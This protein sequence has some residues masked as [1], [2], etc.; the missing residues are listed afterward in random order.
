M[1]YMKYNRKGCCHPVTSSHNELLVSSSSLWLTI[2]SILQRWRWT[3]NS[4]H[5]IGEFTHLVICEY[6]VISKHSL[7]LIFSFPQLGRMTSGCTPNVSSSSQ[8]NYRALKKRESLGNRPRTICTC[9]RPLGEAG[10]FHPRLVLSTWRGVHWRA[11]VW[12]PSQ[13]GFPPRR[14]GACGVGNRHGSELKR[15]T[16][17]WNFPQRNSYPQV[18]QNHNETSPQRNSYPHSVPKP[19]GWIKSTIDRGIRDS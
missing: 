13:R 7:W 8:V 12:C 17:R 10:S 16:P 5:P 2:S 18:I 6:V 14:A 19:R 4:Q 1:T 9:C 11:I 3:G 15:I